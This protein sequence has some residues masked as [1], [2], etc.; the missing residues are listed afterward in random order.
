[1]TAIH[2]ARRAARFFESMRPQD[3]HALGEI[4]REDAT[5]KD[6]FN[7]VA[8]LA[9]IEAVYRHM[10]QTLDDPRFTVWNCTAGESDAWL[11]WH[12]TFRS[13]RVTSVRGAT[14]LQFDMHGRIRSHRDYWDP[15]EELYAHV[16]VLGR[17]LGMIRRRLAAPLT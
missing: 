2:H 13:L 8:G 4:Y 17:L 14:H 15:A 1:M 12:F 5:F 3:L 9:S 11:A 10:F 7:E 16:P 6:P